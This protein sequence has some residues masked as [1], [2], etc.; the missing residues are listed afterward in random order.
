MS[1]S[2]SASNTN[3]WLPEDGSWVPVIFY[4]T[5]PLTQPERDMFRLSGAP[6]MPEYSDALRDALGNSRIFTND[7]SESHSTPIGIELE[8]GNIT[9]FFRRNPECHWTQSSYYV[10]F[11][12]HS[13]GQFDGPAIRVNFSSVVTPRVERPEHPTGPNRP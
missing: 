1:L 2:L 4:Y 13:G 10:D 12:L 6:G 3:V 9:L 7:N 5:I 11:Q 8:D